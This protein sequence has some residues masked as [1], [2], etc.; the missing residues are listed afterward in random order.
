[1]KRCKEVWAVMVEVD[2]RDEKTLCLPWRVSPS[3]RER[4]QRQLVPEEGGRTVGPAG[5]GWSPIQ[6]LFP[7]SGTFQLLGL[8]SLESMPNQYQT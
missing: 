4:S 3:G 2:T 1:M 5:L 7:Q 8:F 6:S